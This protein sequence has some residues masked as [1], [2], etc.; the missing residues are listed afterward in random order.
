[1]YNFLLICLLTFQMSQENILREGKYYIDLDD[2]HQFFQLVGN[3]IE[4]CHKNGYQNF[5][6]LYKDLF[7]HMCLKG[8]FIMIKQFYNLFIQLSIVDQ[9]ALKSMF[10][11][12]LALARKKKDKEMVQWL[13]SIRTKYNKLD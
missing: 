2:H 4:L 11:Y 13:E 6:C 3:Y 5:A 10:P 12:C 8:R 1:L 7:I 9:I